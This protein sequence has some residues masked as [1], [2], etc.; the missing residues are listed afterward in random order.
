VSALARAA[1]LGFDDYDP[2]LVAEAVNE[3]QPLGDT[4][5]QPVERLLSQHDP[6]NPPLGLFWILRTL[7]DA[8]EF[9]PVRLGEPTVPPPAGAE[10]P[11]FPIVLALDL[12][13]LAVR[14]YALAG[15]AEP[16]EHHVTYYRQ[17]GTVRTAPL[18]P[19]APDAALAEFE[20]QWTSA[21]GPDAPSEGPAV[22]REQLARLSRCTSS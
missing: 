7:F 20:R 9:P 2:G 12:P 1:A 10:L 19:G 22:A 18:A 4:A 15:F 6:A 5:L 17:H 8:P 13:L 14:G 11:R 21:Y 16:V 3:L